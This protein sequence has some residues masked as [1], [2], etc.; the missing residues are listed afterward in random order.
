MFSR[1]IAPESKA[2]DTKM[3]RM[4]VVMAAMA[5]PTSGPIADAVDQVLL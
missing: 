1:T 2:V 3:K 5:V 4:L